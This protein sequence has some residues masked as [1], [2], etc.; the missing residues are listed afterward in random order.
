MDALLHRSR[1]GRAARSTHITL[2]RVEVNVPVDDALFHFPAAGT[3]VGRALT[4]Q[5][6]ARRD[7][8]PRASAGRGPAV[9]DSGVLSGLGARNIGSAAMSGRIS[10]VAGHERGRQDHA[11]RRR[12]V[13]RRVEVARRRHDL[14]A[15]LRQE[16]GAVDRRHRHRSRRTRRPSGSAPAR[17]GRATRSRSATA[18]TSRPTAARPGRT[19]AC[20]ESER[21]ARIV[22]DPHERRRRLRLRARA[23]SG[24]TAPIAASTRPTD[25]GKTLVAGAQG[26]KP[27]HRLLRA[28]PWTRRTPT[29]SSPGMWDFRR[30]GWTF[31]SG[32]DGPDAPSGSGLYRTA[33]GG[34]TWTRAHGA[35]EQGPA[36]GPVGPRRGRRSR[37]PTRRSSTRFI[38]SKASALYRSGDGGATWERARQQPVHGLAP[39]LLRAPRRRPARTP[40]GSS[41]RTCTSSSARTAAR[42]SPARGGG[43]HGDW[44]DLWIDP[45]NPKHIIG[46]DDG[47][48]WISYDGGSRWWKVEQPAHLAV[49]SRQRRRQGSRTRS[50]AACRTTAPGSATRPY[51]GGITNSAL[52]EPLR[53]RRLLGDRRPD[54]PRGASTPSRRAATSAASTAGRTRRATS[55]RRPV[56]GEAPLQLEHADRTRAPRSKG[57]LYIGAQFLFRS[58]DRGD[59]WERISPDLTTNDPEKQ[60]QEQSGG[61]TV[62]NS[63]AEMHTT[64]YSISESPKDPQRHLGRDR[65]RQP[66]AHARRRARLD[67]RGRQRAGPARG[68]PG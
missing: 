2:E 42:A 40:T 12:G 38:E 18:S 10:A 11:L 27:L 14:Q 59:T 21:I 20:P 39:V 48:L 47:G 15:R 50:T 25:G 31:R 45:T 55:S 22:V 64:I 37:R 1:P 67:Q 63:S 43:S 33:D 4:P 56:Q 51:P 35:R 66:P 41:S 7:P 29:C 13:G 61:V 65:R 3:H 34:E 54:R 16:P 46:G 23:S 60:K 24:A 5:P 36:A 52:G 58:R 57:T 26:A 17:R 32:G 53:R 30:K 44:H 19:W 28:S 9:I 68:A 62:D 49:L 8:A 6:A